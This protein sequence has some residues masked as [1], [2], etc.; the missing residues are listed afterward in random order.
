MNTTDPWQAY[1]EKSRHKAANPITTAAAQLNRSGLKRAVD[2]GCGAGQ[3]AA[4]L[5]ELGYE[6][7]AYDASLDAVAQ[8]EQRF[9][10][11]DKIQV[12]H[13]RFETFDYPESGVITAFSS[14]F[15]CQPECFEQAW[16]NLSRSLQTGGVF[17]G[18]FLGLD[19][20]WASGFR[21]PTCPLSV[22]TVRSLFEPFEIQS[23]DEQ[24]VQGPTRLGAM[25]HWHTFSV[26][27][28]KTG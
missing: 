28:V 10:G 20:D 1:L 23:F 11:C 2:V 18:H 24:N 4:A 19:D 15:F 6:V 12:Q 3:D 17:V 7:V 16:E 8:C 13:A 14:L 25:K 22:D 26:L 27:A 21:I 5:L 9:A